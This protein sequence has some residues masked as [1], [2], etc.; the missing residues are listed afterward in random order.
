[1]K[2]WFKVHLA[3]Y[4]FVCLIQI[5]A[6]WS[7]FCAQTPNNEDQI[8][9]T[10]RFV[11]VGN[12]RAHPR[13]APTVFHPEVPAVID[14]GATSSSSHSAESIGY[15]DTSSQIGNR[16]DCDKSIETNG[17]NNQAS[18]SVASDGRIGKTI[19]TA[20]F[21]DQALDSKFKGLSNGLVELNKLI[22][23]IMNQVQY[24][25]KYGS[26]QVP[27]TIKLVLVE[28]LKDFERQGQPVPNAERGDI[29]AYLSNFCNW[30]QDRLERDKRLWW[31]HAILL[32][33]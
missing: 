16:I 10:K 26:L 2:F 5:Q 33:G 6:S 25:F 22:L 20:V 27:I 31:D 11:P 30:Q 12:R 17:N 21:I 23:T 7:Q 9:R 32:S 29:D 18:G 4:L 15:Q 14:N 1:M 28:H 3:I 24:L 19:E 8:N 13:S